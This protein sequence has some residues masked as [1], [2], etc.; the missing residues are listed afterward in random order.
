MRVSADPEQHLAWLADDVE[1]GFEEINLHCV[2]REQQ[3]RF[4]EVFGERVLPRL[5]TGPKGS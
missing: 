4:I 5:S 1:M 3:E 2:H